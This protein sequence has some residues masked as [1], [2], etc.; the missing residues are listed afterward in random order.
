MIYCPVREM[1]VEQDDCCVLCK[2]YK[3]EIDTCTREEEKKND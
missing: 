3:E 2:F 1:Y